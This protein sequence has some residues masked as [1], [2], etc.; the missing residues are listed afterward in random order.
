MFYTHEKADFIE[1]VLILRQVLKPIESFLSPPNFTKL[2]YFPQ[3]DGLRAF[4]VLAVF[5]SHMLKID[6]FTDIDMGQAGVIL[7]FVISGLLISHILLKNRIQGEELNAPKR[8]ILFSFYMRRLIRIFPIYYLTIFI[9]FMIGYSPIQKNLVWVLSYTTNVS[10]AING[11]SY[12]YAV[13]LWTLGIEEQFYL[14]LPFIILFLKKEH[15]QYILIGLI[16]GQEN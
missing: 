16:P 6:P 9:V 13:H 4:A 14:F 10:Q 2:S 5:I 11:N 8:R 7:F 1:D 15:I 12:G 3:I